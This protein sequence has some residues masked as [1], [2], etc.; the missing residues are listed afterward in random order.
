MSI[1]ISPEDFLL[2]LSLLSILTALIGI[3]LLPQNGPM[4]VALDRQRLVFFVEVA[5]LFFALIY[6]TFILGYFR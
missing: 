5:G 6:A 2:W 1:D 4:R 3:I